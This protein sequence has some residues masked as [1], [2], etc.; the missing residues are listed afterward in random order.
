MELYLYSPYMPS[1][2]GHGKLLPSL[3]R[4]SIQCGT[5][6]VCL[7]LFFLRSCILE[8][9]L[10]VTSQHHVQNYEVCAIHWSSSVMYQLSCTF[11]GRGDIK[12]QS[13]R[14]RHVSVF[15][16]FRFECGN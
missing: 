15:F 14:D 5:Y 2:C 11:F 9:P 4:L 6:K 8:L 13:Q 12:L 7:Y 10:I 3:S 1:W 16:N